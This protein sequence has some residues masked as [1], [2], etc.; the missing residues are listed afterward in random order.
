MTLYIGHLVYDTVDPVLFV[1]DRDQ[2]INN[3]KKHEENKKKSGPPPYPHK[4][5]K[6][7]Y[8]KKN[9]VMSESSGAKPHVHSIILLDLSDDFGWKA[10]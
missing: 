9:R 1:G 8:E 7:E 5:K 2:N 3:N 10:D 4:Q 6:K